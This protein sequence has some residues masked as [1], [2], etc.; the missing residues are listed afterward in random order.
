M[1]IR[2][3]FK[4]TFNTNQCYN[5]YIGYLCQHLNED[6]LKGPDYLSCKLE[7]LSLV[8]TAICRG[9]ETRISSPQCPY[10]RQDDIV[11]SKFSKILC[12]KYTIL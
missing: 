12:G 7:S 4:T 3:A 8:D 10:W 1:A 11:H 2:G 6:I 5:H 9:V